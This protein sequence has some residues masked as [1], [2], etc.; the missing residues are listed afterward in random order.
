[1]SDISGKLA[2]GDLATSEL[3]SKLSETMEN[4]FLFKLP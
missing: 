4:E 3:M 1:M 2:T